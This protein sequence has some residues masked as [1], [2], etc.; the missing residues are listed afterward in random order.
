MGEA[1][2]YHLT[3][4]PLEK[5][6]RA[7]LAKARGAGW[8]V[9]VRGVD[10]GLME[11]LDRSLWMGR[12]EEFLA[13]GLA[14]GAHDA[15]QPILLT[16]GDGI[17]NGATCLM[18]VGGAQVTVEEVASMERVF[19]LFDETDERAITSARAQWK[20]LDDQGC[21]AK[22]WSE[23]SGSWKMERQIGAAAQPEGGSG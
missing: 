15:E 10:P 3:R 1:A 12:D 11:R 8:R 17:P 18:S 7:L 22:Y 20:A 4:S 13:H 16:A 21:T 14:G 19:L 23:K 9:V 5:A 2:F 6:L